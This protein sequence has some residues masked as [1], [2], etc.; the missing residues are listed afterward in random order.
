MHQAGRQA[1][2]VPHHRSAEGRVAGSDQQH[3]RQALLSLLA[4]FVAPP[5]APNSMFARNSILRA[6]ANA[7]PLVPPPH[8]PKLVLWTLNQLGMPLLLVFN[9]NVG[10]FCDFGK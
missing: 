9:V 6:A 7:L 1:A 2:Y 8:C 10:W 3:L 5:R 4:G